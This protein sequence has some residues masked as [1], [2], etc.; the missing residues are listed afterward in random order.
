MK[1]YARFTCNAKNNTVTVEED[2]ATPMCDSCKDR[3]ERLAVPACFMVQ[4]GDET[5]SITVNCANGKA[6]VNVYTFLSDRLASCPIGRGARLE[7]ANVHVSGKC[8]VDS[9]GHHKHSLVDHKHD[10]YHSN[11]RKDTNENQEGEDIHNSHMQTSSAPQLLVPQDV[12]ED[13][14]AK[15]VVFV[16]DSA[17]LQIGFG[18]H[19]IAICVSS[20]LAVL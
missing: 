16:T 20:I 1:A 13:E 11:D 5:E 6:V 18:F 4:H 3:R 19:F 14:K 12:F 7:D 17:P 15:S 8:E 9:H 10:D 2:C